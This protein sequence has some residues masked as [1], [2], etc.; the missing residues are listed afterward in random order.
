MSLLWPRRPALLAA[1]T[2]GRK[3]FAACSQ[4]P[5]NISVTPWIGC[6]R[7]KSSRVAS[8]LEDAGVE[9]CVGVERGACACQATIQRWRRG[10]L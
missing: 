10:G 2:C 1:L 3:L 7:G 9:G 4:T 8:P 5:R 6:S